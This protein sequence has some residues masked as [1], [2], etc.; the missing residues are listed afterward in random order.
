MLVATRRWRATL[1]L[2]VGVVVAMMIT[3]LATRRVLAEAPDL[4][5]KPGGRAAIWAM[6]GDASTGL[7]RL[8][9]VL[10]ILAALA[11]IVALFRRQWRRDDLILVGAVVVGVAVVAVIGISIISLL[12][13]IVAGVAV[14]FGVRAVLVRQGCAGAGADLARRPPAQAGGWRADARRSRAPGGRRRTRRR[15]RAGGGCPAPG[16]WRGRSATR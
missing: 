13:G 7:F 14:V 1:L 11:V 3:R 10:T 16:R 4:A 12:L 6:L 15:R 8:A 5:S 2:G 9:G